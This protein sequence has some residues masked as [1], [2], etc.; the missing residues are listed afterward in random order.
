M[1]PATRHDGAGPRTIRNLRPAFGSR[2]A[3][4][5]LTRCTVLWVDAAR[6]REPRTSVR[7]W[8]AGPAAGA[9]DGVV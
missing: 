4:W 7:G 5:T 1:Y 3:S 8:A 6:A 9:V 2:N